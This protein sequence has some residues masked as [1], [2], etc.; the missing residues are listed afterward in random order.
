MTYRELYLLARQAPG[1]GRGGLPRARTPPLLAQAFWA[2]TAPA[3]PFTGRRRP[4]PRKGGGL[5]P[6]GGGA[7]CP[8]AP[9]V[10][11]GGMGLYGPHPGGGGGRPL[12]PGGHRRAGGRPGPAAGGR[13]RPPGAWTCAPAPGRWRWGCCTLLP[14]AEVHCLELSDRAFPY[15]EENLPPPT[16]PA[17]RRPEGDVLSPALAGRFPRQPGFSGLQPPLH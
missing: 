9:A 15:L 2:W 8:T 17:T 6:G 16:G 13:P 7:G 14:Q 10:H 4:S 3:W 1:R 11:P 5:P 12:P